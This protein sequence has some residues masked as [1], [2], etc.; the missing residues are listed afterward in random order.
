M[1]LY[2]KEMDALYYQLQKIKECPALY[3]SH[4]SL[5]ALL[6]YS[7]GFCCGQGDL[8]RYN[9]LTG[10]TEYVA[11]FFHEE[12]SCSWATIIEKH[13]NRG[14]NAFEVFFKLYEDYVQYHIEKGIPFS[15]PPHYLIGG[16]YS[17]QIAE[18]RYILVVLDYKDAEYFIGITKYSKDIL[19]DMESIRRF[20]V[21]WIP[22]PAMIIP[23][24]TEMLG[25]LPL[26]S[27]FSNIGRQ[28]YSDYTFI[29]WT[30]NSDIWENKGRYQ[31]EVSLS[32][33]INLDHLN[34]KSIEEIDLPK[35]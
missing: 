27:D 26:T 16:L 17:Y 24:K 12:S 21:G 4:S 35:P 18:E 3:L 15:P 1:G 14:E 32:N 34:R 22:F 31:I 5:D 9:S 13:L 19:N 2:D 11:E 7:M 10:F 29:E 25:N 6:D 30:A 23:A 33:L 20:S 8:L 28:R